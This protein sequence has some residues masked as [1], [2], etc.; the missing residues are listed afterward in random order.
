MQRPHLIA[1][2]FAVL[3][4]SVPALA[5]DDDATIVVTATR[6]PTRASE[7]LSDVTTLTRDDIEQAGDATLPEL[8]NSLP[9][10]QVSAGGGRGA[11]GTFSLRGTNSA[12][13]LVLIDGQRVSSATVGT[14]AIEHLPVEQIER[15]EV[16]RGPASSLYGADA[17]GG[18]IQIITRR[19]EGKPAPEIVVGAGRYDTTVGS[20]AYGGRSGD[21]RFHI[22]AGE[23][24][25][26]GF[27]DV[28]EAK[29]GTYDMYNPDRDGYDN[30]NLTVSIE[31]QLSAGLAIG[32]DYF[33]TRGEKHFDSTNCSSTYPWPCTADFDN[34]LRQTLDSL[35]VHADYHVTD[36]W[37]TSLRI[38]QS[39]DRL[40]NWQFDPVG[41][42]VTEP[43]YETRDNQATWQNDIA[44]AGGKLMAAAEWRGVHVDS[45]QPLDEHDQ[46]TMAF[47]LGYQ[48]WLGDHSLQAS[49]RSDSISRLGRHNTGSLAYGYRFAD[50]WIA[51]GSIG[52]AFHAPTFNDLYW[53]LDTV[54]FYQGN[55]D[56]KPERA[57][58]RDLGVT[59]EALGVSAN[60]TLYYN[61]ITDLIDYV[62]GTAPTYIG[63]M[64][65]VSSATIKGASFQYQRASGD[66]HWL[67]A[68]DVLSARDD[69]TGKVLQRRAPRSGS[70][71][72]R[73]HLERLNVGTQLR[74][75]SRRFNDRSNSQ[76]LGGYAVVNLSAD[77]RINGDWS[78]NARL[79]NLF[80]KD[81]VVVRSTMAPYNDY[82]VAGRS[83]FVGLRYAPK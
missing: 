83:L 6:I 41:S 28:K 3:V 50:R 38:G 17:L 56:L 53:P 34:R 61:S 63:T 82:A 25:S 14:T 54:N 55:P 81:Y 59:Y 79:D 9:G 20:I 11:T 44:A 76:T 77:Y 15:I 37:T 31:Q 32:A 23:E 40:T 36:A 19:R 35:G 10:I 39:R 27:S 18:V 51:R 66:W 45:T 65:N 46:N 72:V 49:G 12:H 70:F 26:K 67:A 60:A 8:L 48:K 73:Y 30:Q 43:Q 52:T 69:A 64:D 42:I 29:G 74:A 24:R 62:P 1:T 75:V 33:H 78:V 5:A 58:N 16:L 2:A 47:I 80:D 57:R 71:E 13:T 21:T 7:V 68:Y 4:A 22:Q